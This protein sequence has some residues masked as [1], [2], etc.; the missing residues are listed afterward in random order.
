MPTTVFKILKMMEKNIG[1]CVPWFGF[2]FDISQSVIKRE[3]Y[4]LH[5][6]IHTFICFL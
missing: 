5:Q 3:I 2:G 6:Y 1:S 4:N